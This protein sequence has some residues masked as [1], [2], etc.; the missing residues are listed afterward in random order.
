MDGLRVG[1]EECDDCNNQA[2]LGQVLG[3]APVSSNRVLD[4]LAST[5]M[6]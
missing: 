3:V 2:S 5:R 1:D 4:F 6:V